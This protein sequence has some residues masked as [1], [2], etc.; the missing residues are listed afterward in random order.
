MI[1]Y[2]Y[3]RFALHKIFSS[4]KGVSN[5]GKHAEDPRPELKEFVPDPGILS[6]NKKRKDNTGK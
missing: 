3:V 5:E 6:A 2:I 1:A 4:I